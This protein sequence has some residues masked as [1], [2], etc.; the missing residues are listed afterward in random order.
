MKGNYIDEQQK[1]QP[2]YMGCYGIGVSRT[3]ATIYEKSLVKDEKGNMG[4][5]LPVN[6]A[7]YLL[8]IISKGEEKAKLAQTLYEVLKDN[9]IDSILDDRQEGSIGSKIKDCKVLG[10]PY[11]AILGERSKGGKIEVE[12]SA[13]GEKYIMNISQLLR[14]MKHLNKDRINN[15]NAKL[16]D[17][18]ENLEIRTKEDEVR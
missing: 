14:Y 4:I 18:I 10:T 16:S 7:P 3:V 17:Y 5:A 12:D 8:Q 11:I 15:P 9:D 13:T 1:K 2:Y 6:I